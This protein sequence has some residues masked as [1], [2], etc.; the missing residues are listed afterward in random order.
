VIKDGKI[1]YQGYFGY[2]D[3]RNKTLVDPDTVFY[4]ASATKPFF[5]LNALILTEQ[6]R[7]RSDAT[8]AELFPK[9]SFANLDPQAVTVRHLLTHTSGI[10]N[11]P[12]VWATAYTGLHDPS[13]RLRMLAA[14]T[15]HGVVALG[16][17][18]YSNVGYNVMSIALEQ[19]EGMAW[20]QQ[21]AR[22]VFS[23]LRMNRTS[24]YISMA[25][26]RKWTLASPYSMLSPRPEQA[27]YLRK[28]D[29]TM[30]AAGGMISTAPDLARFLLAQLKTS[31]AQPSP[32]QRAIRVQQRIQVPT[33][34]EGYEDFA[35]SHYA[36]GWYVGDYK[37]QRMLHHFG[38]FAG[39]HAH[40]SFMPEK[41]I[42]LV[43]LNNEDFLSSKLTTLIADYCYGTL[44]NEAD[45][46]SKVQA[47]FTDLR[48]KAATI[49]PNVAKQIAERQARQ[50]R[51]SL[52]IAAYR[53]RYSHPLAGTIEVELAGK[54]PQ[55]LRLRWG[56]LDSEATAYT[57]VD[58]ARIEWV[59]NSGQV[60]RF[61]AKDQRIE[62]L[63]L[64]GIRFAR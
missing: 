14:S 29:Q 51:L 40:L 33:D 2:A 31:G 12:L 54:S 42:G 62:A 28:V 20:Q 19:S 4:V 52:P 16:D 23:P 32:L 3:V 47:R 1:L 43:V 7:L 10:A 27:L 6:A 25:A 21:L 8:L 5:A 48:A 41:N 50:W 17:F 38:G 60:L 34:G 56:Q 53:G 11:D 59:P 39:F 64:E 30:Q 15:P 18:N 57:E 26:K 49:A 58:T 22:N 9:L 63:E 36:W 45:I 46:A 13:L 55:G 24:A 61:F 37:Q 44:L 35:R